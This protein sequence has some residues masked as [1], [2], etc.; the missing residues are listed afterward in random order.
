[1]DPACADAARDVARKLQEA[2]HEVVELAPIPAM[3]E[4]MDIYP[5]TIIPAW[6][7]LTHLDHP[8][9]LQPYIQRT[10]ERGRG[11]DAT[12]YLAEARLFKL[13]AREIAQFLFSDYDLIITP[14]AATRVPR[15]GVVWDEL[16]AKAPSRECAVYEQCLA[17][18]TV[19]SVIGSPAISLPTTSTPR[20]AGGGAADRKTVQRGPA[21]AGRTLPRTGLRLAHP[22]THERDLTVTSFPR[23]AAC[24]P[25]D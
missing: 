7:S 3:A 25:P 9:K 6:L 8:E 16:R 13:R 5:R 1:M 23:R 22:Q 4:V 20:P 21:P 24:S 15:I 19:P 2:G 17:F 10:I 11:I 12:T 14:T 18:T